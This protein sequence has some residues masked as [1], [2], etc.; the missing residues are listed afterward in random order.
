M[1]NKSRCVRK[2]KTM[3][4]AYT[5]P[6]LKEIAKKMAIKGYNS[7]SKEKLC[8]E[9]QKKV[10]NNEKNVN[11]NEKKVNNN[12][13]NVNKSNKIQK[14]VIKP[15]YYHI[16]ASRICYRLQYEEGLTLENLWSDAVFGDDAR[17]NSLG[18]L[19]HNV[20]D[21]LIEKVISNGLIKEIPSNNNQ[22]IKEY[23]KEYGLATKGKNYLETIT[24]LD[25]V[26]DYGVEFV[27]KN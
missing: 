27:I 21:R 4:N 24:D 10:N 7:M 13:K 15:N 18:K 9:I 1:F 12:E 23:E 16:V 5:I 25:S 2:S 17:I 20:I 19:R 26:V 11:N 22:N 3:P 14:I 8:A 6:E